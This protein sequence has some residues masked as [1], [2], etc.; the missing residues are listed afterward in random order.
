V[1]D[2][3][4]DSNAKERRRSGE[5]TL[6]ELL[7]ATNRVPPCNLQ[8]EVAVLGAILRC[9]EICEEVALV[10]QPEDFYDLKNRGLY[11]AML[12]YRA[13]DRDFDSRLLAYHMKMAGSYDDV[14]GA[15]FIHQLETTA[16]R[17]DQVMLY[18]DKVKETALR[19]QLIRLATDVL[20]E[21]Y[22]PSQSQRDIVVWARREMMAIQQ[23]GDT[24]V[25]QNIRDI[26]KDAFRRFDDR[27]AGKFPK[28]A[29]ETGFLDLDGLTGGLPAGELIVLAAPLGM[30]TTSFALNVSEY[31]AMRLQLHT[32]F[33][34]L[35]EPSNVLA[36][37]LI[38]SMLQVNIQ[39]LR[40]GTVSE[41]DLNR[42]YAAQL[43]IGA[44][45]LFFDDKAHRTVAEIAALARLTKQRT[46][47][48]SLIVVDSLQKIRPENPHIPQH[49]QASEAVSRLKSLAVELNVPVL[50]ITRLIR[51]TNDA[52]DNRPRLRHLRQVGA[53][54]QFADLVLFLHRDG[55]Y[56]SGEEQKD[57]A[58]RA[59]IIVAKQ[60]HGPVGEIEL[61]WQ[62]EYARFASPD[63]GLDMGF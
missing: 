5:Q 43:S 13:G 51:S 41:E 28:H 35:D 39:R 40:D 1:S 7:H 30:G 52:D 42:L 36:D 33:V 15:C 20:Q 38:C 4:N 27:M 58:S 2:D 32:L 26:L 14:C 53:I 63:E 29:V 37:R 45:A 46:G 49:E 44:A 11:E 57:Y 19:R 6:G 23:Q 25:A 17:P 50:C 61:R 62:G 34:S 24:H 21:S 55:Y 59:G 10:L 3:G 60:L 18:A 22:E 16:C 12:N 48:L 47:T 56:H 54:E 8:S 31:V 9:P